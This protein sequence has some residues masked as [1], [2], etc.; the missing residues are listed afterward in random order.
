MKNIFISD[1]LFFFNHFYFCI[2]VVEDDT[3]S[4][5]IEAREKT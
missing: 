1:F 3:S 2:F 5:N 4:G